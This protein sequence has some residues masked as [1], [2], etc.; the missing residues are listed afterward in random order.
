MSVQ[1]ITTPAGETLAVLPKSEYEALI[2]RLEDIVD[3][4]AAADT[5]ARINAGEE[6]LIPAAV[7]KRIVD[8]E[9]KVRVWREHRGMSVT[10]LAKASGLSQAYVSQIES[11]AR[12]A[13]PD[14]RAAIAEALN[15]AIDDLF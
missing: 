2:E 12:A 5:L 4:A 1:Y 11:G 10:A 13:R 9:N 7:V 8:G 15:L 6:E 3:S 14:K